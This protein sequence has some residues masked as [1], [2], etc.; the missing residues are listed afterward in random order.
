MG[1][2]AAVKK[3]LE[4]K[5]RTKIIHLSCQWVQR[6][7][8][9]SDSGFGCASSSDKNSISS[10][11]STQLL[12]DLSTKIWQ[13]LERLSEHNSLS[14][15]WCSAMESRRMRQHCHLPLWKQ[16]TNSQNTIN[17]T[18]EGKHI[19]FF[20]LFFCL[21]SLTYSKWKWRNMIETK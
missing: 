2:D 18:T 20:F 10:S 9:Q 4:K 19:C 16:R 15:S 11:L 7:R 3:N 5:R 13:S 17:F 6:D 14:L 21:L 1:I 12:C 8:E